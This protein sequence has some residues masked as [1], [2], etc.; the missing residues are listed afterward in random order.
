MTLAIVEVERRLPYAPGDLAR[1]VSDVKTYPDFIPWVRKLDVLS[2][3]NTEGV[4]EFVA[5]A[6]VGW[7]AFHERFT[8]RVRASAARVDVALVDGPFRRLENTW[9][10]EE[11]GK[12]GSIVRFRVAFEFK[13]AILQGVAMVNRGIVAERIIAAF[14]KEAKRRYGQKPR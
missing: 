9:R 8:S 13:S 1:L 10:F 4:R 12:G 5:R 2:E 14:D 6:E 3:T 7:R 11:D